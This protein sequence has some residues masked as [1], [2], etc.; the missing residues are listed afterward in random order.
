LTTYTSG[1]LTVTTLFRRNATNTCG[2]VSTAAV[3]VTVIPAGAGVGLAPNVCGC[4]SGLTLCNGKCETT[5]WANCGFSVTANSYDGGRKMTYPEA[6]SY[7][8]SLG[9]GW[10]LPTNGELGCLCSAINSFP[11]TIVID[12]EY[13]NS[14]PYPHDT[15]SHGIV[16]IDGNY[17][18][19]NV[20]A[21]DT[22]ENYVRCV[23]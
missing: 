18:A 6:N 14:T 15:H 19:T 4:A 20:Y 2:T 22:S 16:Y 12:G 7:C 13:W 8:Q 21:D 5:C 11:G 3:T 1:A 9:G 17:C 23:R 10:R